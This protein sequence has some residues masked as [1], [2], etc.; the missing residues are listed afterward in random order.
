MSSDARSERLAELDDEVC[1]AL[2]L[3]HSIDAAAASAPA[4][5]LGGQIAALVASL[6]KIDAPATS[7]DVR[8]PMRLVEQFVDADGS[9]DDFARALAQQ[10]DLAEETLRRQLDGLRD[11][12]GSITA[13]S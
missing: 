1:T 12:K 2:G 8:L 11:L 5:D 13:D 10:V 6:R 9:P 7:T 3:L 4:A